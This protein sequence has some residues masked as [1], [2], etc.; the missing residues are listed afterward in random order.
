MSI[1]AELAAGIVAAQDRD[2]RVIATR[3]AHA[4]PPDCVLALSGELGAGKTTFVQGLAAAWR[5][6]EAV[7]S[8]SFTVCNL[9][10]G[11]RLLVHVDAYRLGPDTNWD[12]LMIEEFLRSPWCLVIEWPERVRSNLP[13]DHWWLRID[14]RE[15]GSRLLRMRHEPDGGDPG[16]GYPRG[17]GPA[18]W[19][20]T[21]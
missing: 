16:E 12:A 19:N 13:A 9:H 10:G 7:T 1:F 4:L 14:L 2:T 20:A 15:D 6:R 3:L 21:H 8:P 18:G 17:T 5:V 11:D